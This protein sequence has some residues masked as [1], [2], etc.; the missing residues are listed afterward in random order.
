LAL[1]PDERSLYLGYAAAPNKRLV[2][3]IDLSVTDPAQNRSAVVAQLNL[4]TGTRPPMDI[5]TDDKG[6]VYLAL[7]T[8][9]EVYNSNLQTP[10]LHIISGFTACEGVTTRRKNGTLV[11][12]ATDR[13]DKTL[14]RFVLVEGVGETI[15]SSN[16]TGLDGDGEVRIIGALSP[17]G[18]DVASDGTVWIADR[19]KGKVYR[20]NSAGSTVDS[21]GVRGAMDIALDETRGEAYISQ[22]T[23]RTIKVLNLSTGK[24]KRTLTPPAAELN[25]D[26]DGEAGLGA[27]TGIDVASCQRVFVANSKDRSILTGNPADSPFSNVGDN[28]DVKAADTDPVLVVTGKGLTKESAIEESDEEVAVAEAAAVTRYELAQNYP[29]PFSPPERGF[30]GNPSTTIRFALPEAAEV[31]LKIYDIAGRLVQT[32]VDGIV[33]VGRHQVVWDGTNQHGVKVASGIYFYQLCA[34]EFTQVRKMSLVR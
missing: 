29:N 14:E 15:V 33:E 9:I 17:R 26:L 10:P 1:S 18:L 23:L 19:G 16:K 8:Q 12:Y 34:G 3:K 7:G 27:L 24:A 4:P 28:N 32:L 25:I 31:S 20:V 21:T 30:A 2:R 22:D 5:A 11:V 6:R 13:R